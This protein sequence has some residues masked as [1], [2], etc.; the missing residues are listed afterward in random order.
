VI[1]HA[2]GQSPASSLGIEEELFVVDASTYEPAPFPADGFDGVHV[3]PELFTTVV[4]LA[5]RICLS[6]ADAAHELASLRRRAQEV[7]GG[8]GLAVAGSGTWPLA[9]SSEQPVTPDDGY[10]RFVDY[11]GPTA[12]RQYCSGLH[13]HV[14]VESPERCFAALEAVLPWLPVL[15]AVSASSPYLDGRETG[16]ASMRAELLGLLPRSGAPPVFGSYAAW[17]RF[18]E[19][20]LALGIIDSYRRLWWDVRPHPLFGTLE[21]RIAD[22]PTRVEATA[23]FAALVQALVTAAP[24]GPAADRGLY[25]QNRW[26]ASRF[27]RA[28]Q[29]VHPDGSRLASAGDLLAELLELVRPTAE[30]LGTMVLL[31]PLETLDQA[32]EQLAVGRSDG[33]EALCRRLVALT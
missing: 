25:A 11:A 32:E 6:P 27:G 7:A 19:R 24:D 22:Q 28:A 1:E 30:R 29:L 15:L 12:R 13:V 14:G 4:E 31:A 2:F 5:T 33:L 9:R 23:A 16:M 18:A 21:V 20:L 17:E 3:K 8:V 10:R 26:A